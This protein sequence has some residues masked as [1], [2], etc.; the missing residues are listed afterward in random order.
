MDMTRMEESVL[1]ALCAGVSM[2]EIAEHYGVSSKKVSSLKRGALTKMGIDNISL[3]F[4][5]CDAGS[6]SGHLFHAFIHQ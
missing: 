3:F 6:F 2:N 4:L 1:R 5:S